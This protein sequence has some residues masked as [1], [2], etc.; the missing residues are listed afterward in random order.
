MGKV[1]LIKCKLNEFMRVGDTIKAVKDLTYLV[2]D[3]KGNVVK[4]GSLGTVIT[5]TPMIVGWSGRTGNFRNAD[6]SKESV[7]KCAKCL[8]LR[9]VFVAWPDLTCC[10]LCFAQV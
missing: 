8:Q 1:L 9:S 10:C 6:V 5:T 7:T 3:E 4:E 2:G